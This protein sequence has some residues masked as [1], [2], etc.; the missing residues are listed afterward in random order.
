MLIATIENIGL[1]KTRTLLKETANSIEDRTL[2]IIANFNT[3][4]IPNQYLRGEVY[5]CSEGNIDF[6]SQ[7]SIKTQYI[8]IIDRLKQK[9][10]SKTWSKIY[11]IPTGHPTLSLQIKNAV[12]RVTR[13]ET[14]DLFYS[15]GEYFDICIN[16]RKMKD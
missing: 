13:L 11:L 7:D 14:T 6:S 10:M 4:H 2:T 1:E 8:K 3:H 16:W 15:N 12:Y 9:L 5:I